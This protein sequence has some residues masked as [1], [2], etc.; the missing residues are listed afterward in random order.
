M[1]TPTS[2]SAHQAD[3]SS[4][5]D[6]V[7]ETRLTFSC[8]KYVFHF[9]GMVVDNLAVDVLAGTPFMERNDVAI[10]PA[11]CQI[12]LD[13]G[14]VYSYGSTGK[15]KTGHGVRRA[16][17]LRAPSKTMTLRP[18]EFLELAL[19]PQFADDETLAL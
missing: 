5:L 16:H 2:Q 9:E 8:D 15:S 7:G 1:V 6:V 18:G 10:R 3:G 4:P 12:T 11:K 13:D 14:T 17:V 19:P